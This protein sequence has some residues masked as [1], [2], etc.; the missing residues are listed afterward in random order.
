MALRRMISKK[1]VDTDR[2]HTRL[3]QEAR[4]AYYECVMNADDDGFVDNSLSICNIN[5]INYQ[6]IEEL[7]VQNYLIKINEVVLIVDWLLQN[8][9]AKDRYTPTIYID[10]MKMVEEIDGRYIL[11]K[12]NDG[13]QRSS[14]GTPDDIDNIV[15]FN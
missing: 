1:I 7:I 15:S 8:K 9:I 6:V 4:L 10:E 12:S 5:Q 11:I 13:S 3:S 2:F 14:M